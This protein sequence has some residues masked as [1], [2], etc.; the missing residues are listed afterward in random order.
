[1]DLLTNDNT[2]GSHPAPVLSVV[3]L[4]VSEA[5]KRERNQDSIFPVP[6]S[7]MEPVHGSLFMVCDGVG[8]EAFGHEASRITCEAI[9][10]FLTDLEHCARAHVLAAIRYA[11]ASLDQF[12][13]DHP[14]AEGMATTLAFLMAKPGGALLAHVGDTRIYHLR[15]GR[16][17]FRTNDHSLVQ[18][19]VDQQLITEEEAL[20]HPHRNVIS[21][22]IVGTGKPVDPEFMEL[23]DVREGDLFFICS[24]GILEGF[25]KEEM[26]AVLSDT[27]ITDRQR[28][29]KLVDQCRIHSRDNFS[30]W[31]VRITKQGENNVEP[32]VG[33]KPTSTPDRWII[34]LN[35]RVRIVLYLALAAILINLLVLL[36]DLF[37]SGGAEENLNRI[38]PS[39]AQI[40]PEPPPGEGTDTTKPSP[41]SPK[42]DN[43]N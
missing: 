41:S 16:V 20:Q 21:N 36:T 14:A 31:L 17:L 28:M 29:Q 26:I 9:G 34:D 22:A 10:A 12:V 38:K 40:L 19:L 1:M 27:L 5:G 3:A 8:G 42:P 35:G 23:H 13:K 25:T 24:D 32:K 30:A 18:N 2:Q 37:N 15:D 11:E 43:S 7:P 39:E 6:P 33:V 4:A